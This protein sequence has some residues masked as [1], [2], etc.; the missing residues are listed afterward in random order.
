MGLVCGRAGCGRS[1]RV[2][3]WSM[4]RGRPQS[5]A[6]IRSSAIGR[7]SAAWERSMSPLK[8][9]RWTHLESRVLSVF[10]ADESRSGSRTGSNARVF[11]VASW[12]VRSAAVFGR[13]AHIRQAS[14]SGCIAAITTVQSG[15]AFRAPSSNDV[16]LSETRSR[17]RAITTTSGRAP[18]SS[19]STAFR[20]ITSSAVPFRVPWYRLFFQ[21]HRGEAC[22]FP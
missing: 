5:G 15:R 10:D 12:S 9:S 21:R 14:A 3:K 4:N 18:C 13:N 7:W 11:L 16:S 22:R 6:T 2:A 19:T 20:T 17:S 8:S 1:Q